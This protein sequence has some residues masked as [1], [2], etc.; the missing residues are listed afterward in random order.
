[1]VRS[2]QEAGFEG[3]VINSSFGRCLYAAIRP[4][5]GS[6]IPAQIGPVSSAELEELNSYGERV[7]ANRKK[8]V[9]KL[10]NA[11]STGSVGIYCPS[12]ALYMLP[13][14]ACYLRFFDDATWI[15]GRYYPPFPFAVESRMELVI[16]PT[17]TV[18]VMSRTF[19][20]QLCHELSR[21]VPSTRFVPI[22]ELDPSKT[23][24]LNCPC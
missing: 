3:K 2:I 24:R 7:I 18:F 12:R 15:H 1:L 11:L 9:V 19:G 23:E 22:S 4:V 20:A 14:D 17:D 5:H 16:K 21:E 10:R 6:Q 8:F 13:V